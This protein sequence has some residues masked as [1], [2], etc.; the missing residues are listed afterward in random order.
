MRTARTVAQALA[1]HHDRLARSFASFREWKGKDPAQARAFLGEFVSALQ[2]HVTWEETLLFPLF[3]RKTGQTHATEAM[4]GECQEIVG[5]LEAI[6]K[7]VREE[8]TAGDDEEKVL[9]DKLLRHVARQ[10]DAVYPELV[11]LLTE[12]ERDGLAEAVA[13]IAPGT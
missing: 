2:W 8:G 5:C 3:E 10:E 7:Q 12:E 1:D 9:L 6:V 4:R 11:R 13:A